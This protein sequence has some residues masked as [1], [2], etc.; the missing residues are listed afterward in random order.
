MLNVYVFTILWSQ[1]RYIIF[2][3]TLFPS[4]VDRFK[5]CEMIS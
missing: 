5:I 4:Y 3:G 2:I 1:A